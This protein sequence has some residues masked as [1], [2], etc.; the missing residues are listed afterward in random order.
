MEAIR[1]VIER[2]MERISREISDAPAATGACAVARKEK[3][4]TGR[5][6]G[7]KDARAVSLWQL[8][9]AG[10]VV[11]EETSC[12]VD[13]SAPE[14]RP[15]PGTAMRISPP[16]T[17]LG[18]TAPGMAVM[19]GK[20]PQ[21]GISVGRSPSDTAAPFSAWSGSDAR[22]RGEWSGRL[23]LSPKAD[24]RWCEPPTTGRTDVD[25]VAAILMSAPCLGQLAALTHAVDGRA[26]GPDAA[27]DNRRDEPERVPPPRNHGANQVPVIFGQRAPVGRERHGTKGRAHAG[28]YPTTGTDASGT[29]SSSSVRTFD[30]AI[31]RTSSSRRYDPRPV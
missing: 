22:S 3:E 26:D 25:G 4:K 14:S 2:V 20:P 23:R 28:M 21:A 11:R 13:G 5:K 1:S 24:C 29:N 7:E 8:P 18:A 17:C 16:P 27:P 10:E 31:N 9:G 12:A 6:Q 19:R 30:A 15:E